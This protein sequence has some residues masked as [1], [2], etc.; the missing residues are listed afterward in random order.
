MHN[1]REWHRIYS[2]RR[3]QGLEILP[4]F[5]Y[6]PNLEVNAEV[7]RSWKDYIQRPNAA[8]RARA[9]RSAGALCVWR[10]ATFAQA[11]QSSKSPSCCRMLRSI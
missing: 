4:A 10:A 11:G 6:P 7:N 3:D 2:E 9:S 5:D 1:D 8:E